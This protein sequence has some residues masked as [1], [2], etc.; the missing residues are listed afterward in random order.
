[1]DICKYMIIFKIS[2]TVIVSSMAFT[3]AVGIILP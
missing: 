2:S 3:G 1:M